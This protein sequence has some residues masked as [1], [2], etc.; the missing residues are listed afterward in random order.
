[1]PIGHTPWCLTGSDLTAA[2][3][4]YDSDELSG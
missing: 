2:D 3:A 4:A 1:M